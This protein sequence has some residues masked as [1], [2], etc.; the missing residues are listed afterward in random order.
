MRCSF[1]LVYA[2][3]GLWSQGARGRL[4]SV[5]LVACIPLLLGQ[6]IAF[7]VDIHLALMLCLS[8]YLMC[9]S[10]IAGDSQPAY[11]AIAAV[12]MAASVKYHGLIYAAV[13]LPAALYCVTRSQR[14]APTAKAAAALVAG[15]AFTAGWYLRNWMLRGNPIF[16][17]SVPTFLRPLLALVRTPY[18]ELPGYFVTSPDT[19]FPHPF[20]PEHLLR[21][22]LRPDMTGDGFGL[23]FIVAGLLAALTLVLIRRIP[24]RRRRAWLFLL[25]M[26]LALGLVAPFHFSVPRYALF[27]PIVLALAPS[28]LRSALKIDR[29]PPYPPSTSSGQALP[30]R[31]GAQSFPLAW[32]ERGQGVR[33]HLKTLERGAAAR[34]TVLTV[35]NVLVLA[36]CAWYIYGNIRWHRPPD[37]PRSVARYAYVEAGHLRIGYLDGRNSFVAALYDERLTNTL[38]PLHYKNY[39]LNYDTEYERPEDFIAHVASL[40]LDYIQIFNPDAPGAELLMLHFPDKT[41]R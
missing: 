16:P 1:A 39:R 18:Q 15:F 34:F 27:A 6:T 3:A 25:V 10:L 21:Y 8:L 30:A 29:L 24:A 36:L 38:I 9:L 11:F 41:Q 20:V 35:T 22:V 33:F 5:A 31:E 37:Q 32:Q 28:V 19:A 23:V 12:F 14:K 13:L 26:T 2:F 7:Y 4:P 40:N 17:L